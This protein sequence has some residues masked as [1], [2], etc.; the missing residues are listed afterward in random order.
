MRRSPRWDWHA[1]TGADPEMHAAILDCQRGLFVAAADIAA[2]PRARDRL[3]P[4]VS[5]VTAPMTAELE[6]SIDQ[7]L[8]G[9]PLAPAFMVP[10]A[11]LTSAALDLARTVPAPRRAAP[12]RRGRGGCAGVRLRCWPTSIAPPTCSTSSLDGPPEIAMSRSATSEVTACGA[13]VVLGA[14][15]SQ[16]APGRP[17]SRPC[18]ET[19]IP[20]AARR[21][22]AKRFQP[23]IATIA[24]VRATICCSSNCA[25]RRW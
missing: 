11:T 20:T 2:N 18:G 17:C 3:T 24:S 21:P 1:P 4:G 10:G 5:A 13:G 23:L 25:A 9:H 6:R 15:P 7:Q 22:T 12:R 14:T 16:G 8:A 19:Y